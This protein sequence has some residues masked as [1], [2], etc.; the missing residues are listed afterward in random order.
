MK[1]IWKH[2]WLVIAGSLVLFLSIGAVAWAA[3]GD[4][5]STSGAV[6]LAESTTATTAAPGTSAPTIQ[7]LRQKLH[8][9][10]QDRIQR[11]EALMQHLRTEMTPADQA[12]YDQLVS[13]LK[14]EHEQIQQI[15]QQVKDTMS[16]LRDLRNKYLTTTTTA[17]G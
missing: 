13:S 12:L 16:Q 6:T 11:Q 4:Q 5:A 15:Q 1:S 14:Q 8:Q 2:K 10:I 9:R 3:T 17:A 7:E